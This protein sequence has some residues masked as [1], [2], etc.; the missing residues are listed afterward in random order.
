MTL[1][2]RSIAIVAFAVGLLLAGATAYGIGQSVQT[3]SS[4]DGGSGSDTV[5]SVNYGSN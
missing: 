1:P 3:A 5:Q 2:K 4:S